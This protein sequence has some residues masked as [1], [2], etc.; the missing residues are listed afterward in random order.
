M[1]GWARLGM[2]MGRGEKGTDIFVPILGIFLYVPIPS[3]FSSELLKGVFVP[4][5]NNNKG[6]FK[7]L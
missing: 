3:L 5:L 6:S 7:G 4:F 1:V 2:T